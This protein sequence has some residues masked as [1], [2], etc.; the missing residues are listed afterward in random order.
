MSR[1]SRGVPGRKMKK[2]RGADP[3]SGPELI[4]GLKRNE[5]TEE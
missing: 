2:N 1:M 3:G 5:E 4:R